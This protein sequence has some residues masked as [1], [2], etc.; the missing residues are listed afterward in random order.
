MVHDPSS[1]SSSFGVKGGAFCDVP[2]SSCGVLFFWC[3]I[4]RHHNHCQAYK[5]LPLY[6]FLN[7]FISS[8]APSPPTSLRLDFGIKSFKHLP[9][10]S[11]SIVFVCVRPFHSLVG[12]VVFFCLPFD[13]LT[14]DLFDVAA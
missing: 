9:F 14:H 1:L 3:G 2:C 6:G 7:Y 11:F 10:G 13:Y 8:L 12:H 5:V 4:V